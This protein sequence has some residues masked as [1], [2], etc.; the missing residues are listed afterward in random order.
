MLLGTEVKK[1][2]MSRLAEIT[3]ECDELNGETGV[4]YIDSS[5][6]NNEIEN[7]TD[8]NETSSFMSDLWKGI[9]PGILSLRIYM[10]VSRK[11]CNVTILFTRN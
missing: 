3:D 8:R 4:I 2:T 5:E 1:V 11:K 10:Y 6:N 7:N 9:V